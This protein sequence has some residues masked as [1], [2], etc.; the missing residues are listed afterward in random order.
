MRLYI[1][2]TEIIIGIEQDKYYDSVKIHHR[3]NLVKIIIYFK[4]T[5]I[6]FLWN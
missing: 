6:N 4:Y 5:I 2:F 1:F 3:K